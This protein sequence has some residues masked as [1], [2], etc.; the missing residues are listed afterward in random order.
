M[1]LSMLIFYTNE[2]LLS[3]IQFLIQCYDEIKILKK[4][5]SFTADS[6]IPVKCKR[7]LIVFFTFFRDEIAN[8]DV[9]EINSVQI[10]QENGG[11]FQPPEKNK[12]RFLTM[13]WKIQGKC[14]GQSYA[15]KELE[16][17]SWNQFEWAGYSY[18]LNSSFEKFTPLFHTRI[19]RTS[20]FADYVTLD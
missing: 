9:Y 20:Y 2:C 17:D 1:F 5:V 19:K 13:F 7:W 15:L 4:A 16:L 8:S 6:P 14:I 10:C 12:H 11:F 3:A 18:P